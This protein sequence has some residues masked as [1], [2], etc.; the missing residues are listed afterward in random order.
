MILKY[1]EDVAPCPGDGTIQ[2]CMANKESHVVFSF[3]VY[4]PYIDNG[5]EPPIIILKLDNNSVHA[6]SKYVLDDT[7][8]KT[9][10][11]PAQPNLEAEEPVRW[12]TVGEESESLSLCIYDD[13]E[14]VKLA[15]DRT[16]VRDC[17][18]SLRVY[19]CI[20]YTDAGTLLIWP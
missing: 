5:Q 9:C 3:E 6:A 17:R 1:A 12:F 10:Q 2:K 19:P 4:N 18:T 15:S 14:C 16:T 8:L 20:S 7:V 11:Q 13:G